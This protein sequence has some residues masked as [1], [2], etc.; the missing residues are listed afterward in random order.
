MSGELERGRSGEQCS[1]LGAR[2]SCRPTISHCSRVP[3]ASRGR[4]V[5]AA[6]SPVVLSNVPVRTP[7]FR[8]FTGRE[9]LLAKLRRQVLA[10]HRVA[11]SDL[12]GAGRAHT[13]LEYAARHRV[14]Y[15]AGVFWV[16][17]ERA[18]VLT[19]SFVRI[20]E[21]LSFLG[22]GSSD[23]SEAV[24]RSL[25]FNETTGCLLIFDNVAD[26][27]QML[28]FVP[29]NN[30][31]NVLI[32]SRAKVFHE[33]DIPTAR[34][35]QAREPHRYVSVSAVKSSVTSSFS[36]R[37]TGGRCLATAR[38]RGNAQARHFAG[39]GRRY[40]P[41]LCRGGFWSPLTAR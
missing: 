10:C 2:C 14:N 11:S 17:L 9:A 7:F 25:G 12:G 18:T 34:G 21:H 33:I 16:R 5:I 1:C 15:G 24:R 41:G 36:R 30:A 13:A 23:R 35:S 40:R 8:F 20:A 4:P 29:T 39:T 37:D 22:A 6:T 26:R 28:R 38:R 32:T 27:S 19:S 3:W 31:G